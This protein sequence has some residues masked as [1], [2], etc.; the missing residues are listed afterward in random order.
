VFTAVALSMGA[1]ALATGVLSFWRAQRV[2]PV[3]ALRAE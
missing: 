3:E 2:N 1:V